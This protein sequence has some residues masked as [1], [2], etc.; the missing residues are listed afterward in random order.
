MPTRRV[1]A[2][3]DGFN[4][5]HAVDELNLPHL[6]WVNLRRLCGRFAP[7]PDFDLVQVNYFSAYATW[8]PDSYRRHIEFVRA[9]QAQGVNVVLG[10]FKEQMHSCRRCGSRWP[11]HEEKE[12]DVSL[13]VH[14]YRGAAR[15]E[16]DRA[17]LVTRDSDILPAVRLVKQDFPRKE[18]R[19]LAPPGKPFNLALLR[20]AG[21]NSCGKQ[22]QVVH[23]QQSLLDREVLDKAGKVV[24]VRPKEYDPP[25]AP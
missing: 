2:F 18:I 25:A 5:Y 6:K 15:D 21:G 14:L 7:P 9:Q 22:L 3:F 19:L 20:A 23:L 10:M 8:L 12:S 4:F 16:Y 1:A 24:A 11:S 13:A 17:L